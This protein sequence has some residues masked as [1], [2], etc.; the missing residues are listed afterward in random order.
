MYT[1]RDLGI[2]FI[3]VALSYT[4]VGALGYLAYHRLPEGIEQNFLN[5]APLVGGDQIGAMIARFMLLF[6]LFSVFPLICYIVRIQFFSYL[7]GVQYP[8]LLRVLGL[9]AVLC[10]ACTCV[11][12]FYPE[13][14]NILR[15][16]GAACGLLYVFVLP[17]AIHVKVG[18]CVL[19]RCHDVGVR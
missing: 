13:I 12:I 11:S 8:G 10:A 4:A 6:Q 14:G 3:L 1:Q 9:N 17:I 2:A 19:C 5:L 18:G 7:M 16:T 15:F